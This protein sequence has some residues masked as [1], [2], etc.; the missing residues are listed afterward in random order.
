MSTKA[1]VVA[2]ALIL[3]AGCVQEPGSA[4]VQQGISRWRTAL[5]PL[6]QAT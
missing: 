5:S 3:I 6:R 4:D 2:I 1:L